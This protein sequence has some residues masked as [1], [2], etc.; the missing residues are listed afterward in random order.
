MCVTILSGW[1]ERGRHGGMAAEDDEDFQEKLAYTFQQMG[2]G[3]DA[4][5]YLQ[6]RKWI[7]EQMRAD[8]D[9]EVKGITE[10][11]QKAATDAFAAHK[12]DSDDMLGVN[13]VADLLRGARAHACTRA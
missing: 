12:R 1:C 3:A 7:A 2:N 9:L 10:E 4:I 13:E 5:N 8:E 11:M 6:L